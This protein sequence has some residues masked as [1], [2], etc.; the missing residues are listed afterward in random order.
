MATL[1]F[2]C[3]ILCCAR[4]SESCFSG[5]MFVRAGTVYRSQLHLRTSHCMCM[6][7]NMH[8]TYF[9]VY[10][11]L[12]VVVAPTHTCIYMYVTACLFGLPR[13]SAALQSISIHILAFWQVFCTLG[14]SKSL[15]VCCETSLCRTANISG[16]INI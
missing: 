3:V 13:F 4:V 14:Y 9:L 7:T 2:V 10:K 1:G 6:R 8:T 15:L 16:F 12:A 5:H 11:F